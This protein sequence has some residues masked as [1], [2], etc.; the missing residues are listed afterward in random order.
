MQ[1]SLSRPPNTMAPEFGNAQPANDRYNHIFQFFGLR[2]NP[3]NIS[4]N[5]RYLS[6]TRQTQEAFD[7]I[8]YGIQTRQ[9]LLLLTGE[10][11]TGKT[12][13]TNYLRD[14]LY[15]QQTPTSFIFNSR[16]SVDD[17]FD[18]VLADFGITCESKQKDQKRALL[19]EWLL[20]CHRAGKTPILIVD[21]AQ[22]LLSAVLEEIRL[23][24]DLEAS[25][26]KLLQVVLV[27]QPELE[28]KLGRPELRPLL[29][30]VTVH[31]KIGPLNSAETPG[32]IQRRL[33]LAGAQD[34]SVF[35]PDAMDALH[36]YSCG[37]P[38][39]INILC[40]HAL[41][42]A[43][44][45]QIRPVT[46]KIVNEVA[47]EFQFDKMA[48][49][50]VQLDFNK[51]TSTRPISTRSIPTIMRAHSVEVAES[52]ARE[53]FKAVFPAV[54]KNPAAPIVPL[55]NHVG[56]ANARIAQRVAA[57]CRWMLHPLFPPSSYPSRRRLDESKV[58][59]RFP[60]L[61]QAATAV[62]RW[63]QK[64]VRPV[65]A[66]HRAD[67][68]LPPAN[69]RRQISFARVRGDIRKGF[70]RFRHDAKARS[71]PKKAAGSTGR[72]NT[73]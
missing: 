39:V 25:R 11:G 70:A 13:L 61:H 37:I 8:T 73:T 4:P 62:F 26:E 60:V 65:R 27:G 68:G 66:S 67:Q 71:F 53:H 43:Y 22:G 49:L 41:I 14:W 35:L 31:C 57:W 40:E 55:T 51:T 56:I 9:G 59:S 64:P 52:T 72:C 58:M 69:L 33:H 44:T 10:V 2:E 48:S 15:Q 36:S 20:T 46:P 38:R 16:L 1:T 63:L 7:A 24:L 5:P 29:E 6:F 19:T 34:E 3:F 12:T 45:D 30:R 32:Y 23:L 42:N 21:E 18:F 50:D 28:E 17:L 47:R 54:Q